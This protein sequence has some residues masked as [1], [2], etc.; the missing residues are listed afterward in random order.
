VI[1]VF[2]KKYRYN[3]SYFYTKYYSDTSYRIL[4]SLRTRVRDV[5]K[6][7]SK[8]KPTV[9]LLGCTA[10]ELKNYLSGFFL[11]GMNWSNYGRGMGKW[12]MDH[13]IPCAIFD[14]TDPSE[15]KQ[16]FHFSNIRPLW[17]R[18][19]GG[20]IEKNNKTEGLN[21]LYNNSTPFV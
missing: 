3:I 2:Y 15:Q 1:A 21:L 13:I 8:S 7:V 14:F 11:E 4:Q 20:N 16:C 12:N 5:L 17:E 18:G 6:G 19:V 10:L 9:E